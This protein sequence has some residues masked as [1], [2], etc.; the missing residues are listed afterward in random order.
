MRDCTPRSAA[1]DS[2]VSSRIGVWEGSPRHPQIDPAELRSRTRSSAIG[3][4]FA[5]TAGPLA[6]GIHTVVLGPDLRTGRSPGRL[7]GVAPELATKPV[8]T[9]TTSLQSQRGGTSWYMADAFPGWSVGEYASMCCCRAPSLV[10]ARCN[11]D[12]L[13]CAYPL[14]LSAG[15]LEGFRSGLIGFHRKSA[16]RIGRGKWSLMSTLWVCR[17]SCTMRRTSSNRCSETD[18]ANRRQRSRCSAN[19]SRLSR[20]QIS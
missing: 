16:G 13:P 9:P 5:G 10:V 2:G 15:Y 3:C 14:E 12:P 19:A 7:P 6:R 17:T 11:T 18:G 20:L 1:H 8:P 4:R